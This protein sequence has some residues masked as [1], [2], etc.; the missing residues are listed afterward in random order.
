MCDGAG[1]NAQQRGFTGAVWSEESD[2]LSLVHRERYIAASGKNAIE[3]GQ[4][5][6]LNHRGASWGGGRFDFSHGEFSLPGE[7]MI[8]GL[9]G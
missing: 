2:N 9:S 8:Q 1:Q 7:H 5:H 6:R 3:F 4:T